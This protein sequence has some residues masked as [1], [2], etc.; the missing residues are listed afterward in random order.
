MDENIKSFNVCSRH[1][2][3]SDWALRG[4]QKILRENAI[5]TRFCDLGAS[6]AVPTDLRQNQESV[7]DLQQKIQKLENEMKRMSIQ[8]DVELQHIEIKNKKVQESKGNKLKSVQKKLL[9]ATS[10][11]AKLESIVEELQKEA[12]ISTEDAKFLNVI[13]RLTQTSLVC[14]KSIDPLLE[15]HFVHRRL[16]R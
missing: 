14:H 15:F 6:A 9:A 7:D 1:F 3:D 4:S 2:N 11:T 13:K 12:L 10:K 5:P 8:H 16:S